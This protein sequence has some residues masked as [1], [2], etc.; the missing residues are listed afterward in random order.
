[1]KTYEEMA[2]DVLKRRDEELR[3]L[4]QIQQIP[5]NDT[6]PE[7]VYPASSK[8][9]R[10]L[11][12]IAIPCAAAVTAAA[13][14]LTIWHNVPQR[15]KYF[16]QLVAE[17]EPSASKDSTSDDGY[18]FTP[19]PSK[20]HSPVNIEEIIYKGGKTEI[21]FNKTE[22]W[23][24]YNPPVRLDEDFIS[25]ADSEIN[26]FY[27][28]E[29]D[30]LSKEKNIFAKIEHEAFGYYNRD[31][32]SDGMLMHAVHGYYSVNK[33]RYTTNDGEKITVA[34]GFDKFDSAAVE[35]SKPSVINGFDAVV[36]TDDKGKFAADI[37]MGVNVNITAEIDPEMNEDYCGVNF[38]E[39]IL[40]SYTDP[41]T[42]QKPLDT[43]TNS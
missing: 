17:I 30:R 33:I 42:E 31:I 15:G 1:M 14:G 41:N 4:E 37:D 20:P 11:P 24:V 9:R 13:V 26:S 29:F 35:N 7:V 40:V 39:K 16:N 34:A 43:D 5:Q 27:G 8:K 28:I 2:R 18:V 36:Y 12:R 38:F 22:S 3:K 21:Y 19:F 32:E 23:N 25:I 6:P 10:L